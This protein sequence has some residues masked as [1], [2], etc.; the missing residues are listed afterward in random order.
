MGGA[1]RVTSGFAGATMNVELRTWLQHRAPVPN[2]ARR[3]SQSLSSELI[4]PYDSWDTF[5]W[6]VIILDF[7]A[8]QLQ[9]LVAFHLGCIKGFVHANVVNL[10]QLGPRTGLR[11]RGHRGATFLAPC[12]NFVLC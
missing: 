7:C 3:K 9:G 1:R 5:A 2:G 8:C 12:G 4:M 10:L 6:P 11:R